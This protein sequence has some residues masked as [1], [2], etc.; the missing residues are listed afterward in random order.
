[1][2]PP[3]ENKMRALLDRRKSL[4]SFRTLTTF[5]PSS[6]DFSSNDFLSLSTSPLLRSAY[7][8]ELHNYPNFRLGSTGSRLLDG[9]STYAEDLEKEI[10]NFHN[11]ESALLFNSGFDA[12]SGFFA[13]APQPGDIIIYDEFV[14]ASAREGIKLSRCSKNLPFRHNSVEDLKRVILELKRDDREVRDGKRS[15]LIAVESLYSMDGDLAP[16]EEIVNLVERELGRNGL[17][18]V[19]EAHSTGIYGDHGRG[20]VCALG[21]EKRIFARLHTCG[22]A[23]ACNGAAILGSSLVREYLINY[24][25]PLIYTT[26]MSFPS[27]AAIKVVYSLMREGRTEALRFRLNELIEYM[28]TQLKTLEPYTEDLTTSTSLLQIPPEMPSSPIFSI[29]MPDP[30]SLARHCQAADFVVRP[31]MPPTVPEGTQRVRVCLHAGNTHEDIERLV[32]AIK[33]WSLLQRRGVK[34]RGG[35]EF[36]KAVL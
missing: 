23:L 2:A 11:A 1:M 35:E 29:L 7:L 14:H 27:L 25:R 18:V 4:S 5:P 21:L 13:C 36:V 31:I 3:I 34:E 33:D 19:D 8:Q 30:R 10:A 6:I 24:A 22:K 9:N 15:V 20:V 32:A 28:Y 16:L 17:L 12:N 26:A